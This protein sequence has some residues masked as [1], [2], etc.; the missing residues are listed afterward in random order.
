VAGGSLEELANTSLKVKEP[1]DFVNTNDRKQ[2]TYKVMKFKSGK[3]TYLINFTV[4][5]APAFGKK[6]NWNAVNVSFGVREE[7]DDYS[8]G[9][10]INTDLT[11]KNKNQFLIY[12]TVINA[13][14]KFITEYNTE[15]DEIIMQGAGER[16]EAIYQ[17]FFQS[18][19]KYFPGWHH[20]GKHSLV[21]DVP[22]QQTKKVKE[23]GVE[24]DEFEEGIGKALGTAALAGSLAL[25]GLSQMGKTT[26]TNWNEYEQ[27]ISGQRDTTGGEKIMSVAG[28]NSKGEYRVRITTDNDMQEFITK[29]PPKSLEEDKESDPVTSAVLNFYKPVVNDIHKEKLPDYVDQARELLHKTNDPD[30]RGKLVDIFKKGK[31]NPYMQGGIVTT[32]GAVLAGGILNTAQ[33]MGLSPAQTNLALQAI[34][35]TVIPTVVSRIN[36]KNWSDTIKYTLASAGIGTGIAGAS[37]IETDRDPWGDQG[38]FAGDRPVNIGG[39]FTRTKL[40]VGDMVK[41]NAGHFKGIGEISEIKD[42]RAEVWMS[43]YSRSFVFDLSDLVKYIPE[44]IDYLEEK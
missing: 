42:D 15:I 2:V 40:G 23:Q 20:D 9:D 41:V 16:Q 21:R 30:I 35:N 32:V 14:R 6:Q 28:P 44:S 18:A 19:G 1:K 29:T 31:E 3:D 13:V 7:Q 12:S 4:K 34:L 17:R 37:L 10:E 8:F 27:Q 36:G 26:D 43:S 22:R 39:S 24:E 5:G 38:N 11:A 25:G 33:Q